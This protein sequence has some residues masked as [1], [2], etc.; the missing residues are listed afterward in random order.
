MKVINHHKVDKI[1]KCLL[2]HVNHEANKHRIAILEKQLKGKIIDKEIS[3]G[4][5]FFRKLREE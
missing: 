2:V 3:G 5:E 1:D 4:Y